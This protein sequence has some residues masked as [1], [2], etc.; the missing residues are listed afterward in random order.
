MTLWPRATAL[1]TQL[2]GL[3]FKKLLKLDACGLQLGAW[4]L[5]LLRTGLS[6]RRED[7]PACSLAL[8]PWSGS[9]GPRPTLRGAYLF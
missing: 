4:S 9:R 8:G 6:S 3:I 1:G 2:I 5:Q 7:F